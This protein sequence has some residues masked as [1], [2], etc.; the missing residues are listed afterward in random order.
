[1][2][3]RPANLFFLFRII[4]KIRYFHRGTLRAEVASPHPKIKK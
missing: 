3:H 2:L 4:V 1:M